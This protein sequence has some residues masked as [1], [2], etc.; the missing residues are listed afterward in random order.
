MLKGGPSASCS[1]QCGCHGTVIV[2]VVKGELVEAPEAGLWRH[3]YEGQRVAHCAGRQIVRDAVLAMQRPYLGLSIRFVSVADT[4]P[5][6]LS[7]EAFECIGVGLGHVSRKLAIEPDDRDAVPFPFRVARLGERPFVSIAHRHQE[8]FRAEGKVDQ[9]SAFQEPG[10]NDGVEVEQLSELSYRL[11]MCEDLFGTDGRRYLLFNALVVD[12]A[13]IEADEVP[14]M[15]LKHRDRHLKL[16]S[17]TWIR[18]G[19]PYVLTR[20]QIGG[21]TDMQ[22]L[23]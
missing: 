13:I 4:K 2:R 6:E 11:R 10:S 5:R 7:I 14:L 23:S 12:V 21:F 1:R 16:R 8:S 3:I 18:D 15:S 17:S 22:D 20:P 19:E 9:R